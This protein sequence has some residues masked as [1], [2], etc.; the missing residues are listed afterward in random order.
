MFCV[1]QERGGSITHRQHLKS[2]KLAMLCPS[3]PRK[4]RAG[5]SLDVELCSA[6]RF[7]SR[8]INAR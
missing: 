3:Q 5:V 2:L 8:L 4:N 6:Y 7:L 1:F